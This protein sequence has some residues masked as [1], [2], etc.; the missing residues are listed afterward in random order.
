MTCAKAA[1]GQPCAEFASLQGAR[2]RWPV[3]Q[4]SATVKPSGLAQRTFRSLEALPASSN[5]SA[6]RYS[7]LQNSFSEACCC[8]LATK[9]TSQAVKHCS[10]CSAC[11]TVREAA[12]A[13]S[14]FVNFAWSIERA[15]GGPAHQEW[16]QS[17]LL[18]WHQHDR[19]Q[20]P[21]PACPTTYEFERRLRAHS[22]GRQS[23]G[24]MPVRGMPSW[25]KITTAT[26][27]CSSQATSS[28]ARH[29]EQAVDT[30]DRKLQP[31]AR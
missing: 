27:V 3:P 28:Q 19:L 13:E 26:Q 1:G 10:C 7:A 12:A 25:I 8:S 17:K 30:P 22:C 11:R 23:A 6:V 9:P 14:W 29:L 2:Y 5:T 21:V 24:A 15:A 16:Q 4:N 31:C 18:Q 20:T